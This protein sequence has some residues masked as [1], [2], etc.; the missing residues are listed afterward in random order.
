VFPHRVGGKG[1]EK[2]LYGC[3]FISVKH[4]IV[5]RKKAAVDWFVVVTP[6][7]RNRSIE[8]LT[9]DISREKEEKEE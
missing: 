3:Q 6:Q 7:L 2:T 5:P 8:D 1:M 9:I 4:L